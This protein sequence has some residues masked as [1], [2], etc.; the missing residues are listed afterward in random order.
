MYINKE[1]AM[2]FQE[3]DILDHEEFDGWEFPQKCERCKTQDNQDAKEPVTFLD[4][5]TKLCGDCFEYLK[6]K[7]PRLSSGFNKES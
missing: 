3:F 2:K 1:K 4:V 7:T 6:E 5:E